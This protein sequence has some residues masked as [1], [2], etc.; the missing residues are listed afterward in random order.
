MGMGLPKVMGVQ[1]RYTHIAPVRWCCARAPSEPTGRVV[2]PSAGMSTGGGYALLRTGDG[3][4]IERFGRRVVDRPVP[5]GSRATPA[6]TDGADLRYRPMVGW[7]GPRDPW[8]VEWDGL[9]LELRA[10]DTGQVGLFPEHAA[11]WPWLTERVTQ[12]GA[13]SVL[14][15]F[16]YT[17]AT[18]LH[19][20]RLGASVTH[21]DA[22]RPTVA[23]ARRNAELSGLAMAPT[24]WIVDDAETFVAREVRRGNRYDGIVLDPPTYGHG[25][26]G[27]AWRLDEGLERLLGTCT[28]LV[29]TPGSFVLLTA[30]T[31]GWD[32]SRLQAALARTFGAG[33]SECG[34]LAVDAEDGST[35][36]LGGWARMIIEP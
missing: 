16:A 34:R 33:R 9:T 28:P 5:G 17:G 12:R 35:L 3:R 23:W 2:S 10:T 26:R 25:P 27:R 4:R 21:V 18:T 20:A 24:R 14:N 1:G 32:E 31:P 6:A 15:L 13:A 29:R 22:S 19:L 36:A 30:H 8:L 11:M 7:A